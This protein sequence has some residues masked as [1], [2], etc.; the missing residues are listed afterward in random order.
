MKKIL[1]LIVVIQVVVFACSK[2]QIVDH[3]EQNQKNLI[4]KVGAPFYDDISQARYK[5]FL[6]NNSGSVRGT[7]ILEMGKGGKFSLQM[8]IVGQEPIDLSV[9]KFNS[10]FSRI[11]FSNGETR[12]YFDFSDSHD[13]Q[14]VEAFYDNIA[15]TAS[16]HKEDARMPISLRTGVFDSSESPGLSGTWNLILLDGFTRGDIPPPPGDTEIAEVIIMH[17]GNIYSDDMMEL[18]NES[19]LC[20]SS[21]LST[22]YV[23]GFDGDDIRLICNN[24][25]SDFGG[26]TSNWEVVFYFG[27]VADNYWDASCNP[28]TSG[29]FSFTTGGGTTS[30]G[31]ILIDGF[32][33]L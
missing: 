28:T 6:A 29:T 17:N 24:Q 11:H 22:P 9:S 4:T 20:V 26:G 7:Y 16:I 19:Q 13:I 32:P 8:A 21:V 10:D 12:M 23:S 2:D 31:T 5:G 14:V 27:A 33:G 18:L 30:N 1:F 25:S 15:L 3:A